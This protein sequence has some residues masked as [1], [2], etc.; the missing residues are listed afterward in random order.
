M[1]LVKLY[2]SEKN[3]ELLGKR[4]HDLKKFEQNS[5]SIA[6]SRAKFI[7][8]HQQVKTRSQV[9]PSRVN[10]AGKASTSQAA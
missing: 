3:D 10:L 2:G 8:R 1:M 9:E 5:N 4:S 6:Q 7:Q